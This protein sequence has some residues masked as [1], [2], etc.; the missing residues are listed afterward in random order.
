MNQDD[1][2]KRIARIEAMQTGFDNKLASLD[3][4]LLAELLNSADKVLANPKTLS[5]ILGSFEEQY[6]IPV[7]QQFGAD[8]LTIKSLN[9]AYFEGAI[10]DTMGGHLVNQALFENVQLSVERLMVDQFGI[11]ADGEIVKNGLFDL[12]SKD[13]TVRREIQQF[14]YGQKASGIGVEKFKKNLRRFIEGVPGN[15]DAPAKGIYKRHYDTVAFDTYQQADRVAQ[16]AFAGGLNMTAFLYL[17]GTIAGTRLFCRVRDGKVFLK[18]EI[19][20]MGT[21]QDKYG[22]YTDKSTGKFAGK[23]PGYVAF[24]DAGGFSC[25]HHWSALSDRAA[26]RRRSDLQKSPNGVLTIRA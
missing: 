18:S 26:M 5:R 7:L 14:A 16:Q 10:G 12:F 6:H 13:T 8:L 1:A 11:A 24:R 20:V 2:K 21:A 4:D 15:P 9:D 17:G 3:K 23:N 25:R 22:G 19:D